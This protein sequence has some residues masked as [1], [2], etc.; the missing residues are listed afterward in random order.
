MK[1]LTIVPCAGIIV[2]L[3]GSAPCH[4]QDNATE[5]QLP[6]ILVE[7]EIKRMT[8]TVAKVSFVNSEIMITGEL[9]YITFRVPDNISIMRGSKEIDLEDIEPGETVMVQ[10][11]NPEPGKYIAVFLRASTGSS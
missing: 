5:N 3:C 6:A 2:L 1:W 7:Q 9:G 11:E 4:S 10:Y 8:G